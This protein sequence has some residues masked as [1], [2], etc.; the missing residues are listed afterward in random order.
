MNKSTNPE[1]IR[2]RNQQNQETEDQRTARLTRERESKRQKRARET[3]EKREQRLQSQRERR[4]QKK[5][6]ETPEESE[7]RRNRENKRKQA[8]RLRTRQETDETYSDNEENFQETEQRE[9]NDS[10]TN[11]R[12]Q[13]TTI[14][15]EEIRLLE[16]FRKKWMI[17]VTNFAAYVTRG[18]HQ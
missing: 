13:S 1:T 7:N 17:Y 8:T 4:R 14:S 3:D 15:E 12:P 9:N 6:T 10:Y 5:I 18:Y 11:I 2:K 16:N